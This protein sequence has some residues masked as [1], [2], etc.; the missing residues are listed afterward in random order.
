MADLF[1]EK[2]WTKYLP[3]GFVLQVYLKTDRGQIVSFSVALIKDSEC[4]TRYDNAHGFAHRDIIGRKAACT[5][6]KER[7]DTLTLNEVFN[8]AIKDI[9][10]NYAKY[11][12]EYRQ[13]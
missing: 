13:H 3:D 8:Y 10:E 9:S 6:E 2:R 7:L 5:L 1:R 12:E 4:V 11:Y